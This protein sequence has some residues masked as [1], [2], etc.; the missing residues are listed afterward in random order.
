MAS[1]LQNAL[2]SDEY[3]EATQNPLVEPRSSWRDELEPDYESEPPPVT[4]GDDGNYYAND[5]RWNYGEW[6]TYT[7]D[8]PVYWVEGGIERSKVDDD[9]FETD[10]FGNVITKD[11]D[12]VGNGKALNP[13]GQWM[14]EEQIRN[15]W[16]SSDGM[17]IFK[18]ANPNMSV[19]DYMSFVKD[20]TALQ[21]QGIERLGE[22]G[23]SAEYQALYDQYGVATE[24]TDSSGNRYDFNGGTYTKTVDG[25]DMGSQILHGA[26]LGILGA[27]ISAGLAPV[28]TSALGP[29]GAKA[30]SSAITSL[31]KQYMMTGDISFE[32]AMISAALSYGGSQLSGLIEDSGV[33]SD[34]SSQFDSVAGDLVNN[35]GD[36]LKSALT[37]GGM[38]L[39]TQMVKEGEIDWK[40]AAIAAAMAGGTTALQGFLSDIGKE[41]A[42]SEVLEEITVTAQRK[43][44][45]VGE[46]LWQLDDGT[47]ISDS[48]NVLGNMDNLDLDGDGVL[49]GNDLQDIDV[50]HDFVDP[51]PNENVYGDVDLAPPDSTTNPTAFTKEWANE[52]YGSLSEGQTVAA[53]QRDGFTDEQIDAYLEGRYDDIDAI[54]P[55]IV[56]HAGGWVENMEQPY[57]LEYRDGRH[58]IIM[59]GKLKAISED[60][61][62]DLYADL[63]SGGDWQQTMNDYGVTSGGEVFGGY[64][65][66]G[67]PIYNQSEMV[68]DW[69]TLDG[70][71]PPVTAPID[72]FTE[73]TPETE[74]PQTS[75]DQESADG[76]ANNDSPTGDPND[77]TAQG[78]G[79]TG[80]GETNE[81]G[82]DGSGGMLGGGGLPSSSGSTGGSSGGGNTGE[83]TVGGSGDTGAGGE[84]TGV[85][86][87]SAGTG[88]NNTN[89]G[90]GSGNATDGTDNSNTDGSNVGGEGGTGSG[91]GSGAGTGTNVGGNT[92]ETTDGSGAGSGTSGDTGGGATTGGSTGAGAGTDAGTNGGS[93]GGDNTG[94][95]TGAGTG[96]GTGAGSGG[97]S[98]GGGA[99]GGGLGSGQGMLSGTGGNANPEWGPLFP[100]TQFKPRQK[101][102]QQVKARLFEDLFKDYM[103]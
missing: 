1:P 20:S 74:N 36:I 89:N 84:S 4:L 19:D 35:G 49:N 65:E 23:L 73:E 97:G 2:L 68:D 37:A 13:S 90:A 32:D 15:R 31:A 8:V 75:T 17:S 102:P 71:Q 3:Q 41:G 22:G 87:N 91:G 29:A 70:T 94:G 39:V 78:Q 18:K 60:A 58:Y 28:L 52:R 7:G 66:Y 5:N 82:G 38:S 83:G 93:N 44:T 6:V 62:T 46:G 79:P 14:T 24:Y 101:G 48:G 33:L 100:G 34:L 30:A 25:V 57:T 98:G 95:S 55:N 67:R 92:G 21:A 86:D 10:E 53:M 42:E 76:D 9:Q 26:V 40:D 72:A 61:Y 77:S 45:Q 103:A 43:G 16:E 63:E 59:D 11:A 85:N 64:D 56:T 96:S 54:N 99:G 81:Q 47:V 88:D 51:N 50:N 12:L 69:I 27:G 80:G